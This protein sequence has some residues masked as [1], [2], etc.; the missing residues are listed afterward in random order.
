MNLLLR[1]LRRI[2]ECSKDVGINRLVNQLRVGIDEKS[3]ILRKECVKLLSD[4][5]S[6]TERSTFDHFIQLIE[7]FIKI[8][9]LFNFKLPCP[10]FL[11][12]VA[13]NNM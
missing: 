10:G 13:Q 8:I 6:K 1:F 7:I 9:E 2:N 11:N 3:R 4:A 12:N 5:F